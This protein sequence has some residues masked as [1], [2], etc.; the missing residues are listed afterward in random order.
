MKCKAALAVD[1]EYYGCELTAPHAGIAHHSSA[2]Q[3]NW[4]SDGESRKWRGKP[5][6]GGASPSAS[7]Q[8]INQHDSV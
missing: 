4:C 6:S 8:G 3:A 1:G 5:V 2:A 7:V